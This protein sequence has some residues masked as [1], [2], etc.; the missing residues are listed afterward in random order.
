MP[1][2]EPKACIAAKSMVGDHQG[3]AAAVLAAP[4]HPQNQTPIEYSGLQYTALTGIMCVWRTG[5]TRVLIPVNLE[6]S[7]LWS[8]LHM[9]GS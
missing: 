4:V 2:P 3:R 1:E 8:Y 7:Y 5:H 9:P 6:Q